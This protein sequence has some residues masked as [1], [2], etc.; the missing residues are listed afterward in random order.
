VS[1]TTRNCFGSLAVAVV[2][3]CLVSLAFA[4]PKTVRLR[5][6]FISTP[7]KGQRA[8]AKGGGQPANPHSGL[9]LIQFTGPVQGDWVHQL[10]ARGVAPVQYV[11]EDAFI[12]RANG[13]RLAE[14]EQLPF[15]RW[16]GLLRPEHKLHNQITTRL[17]AEANAEVAV[18]IL[19][20]ADS[21]PQQLGAARGLMNKVTSQSSLKFGHVWRGTINAAR[22][23]PLAASDAV[24]WVEPAPKI[25]MFDETAS[26]I[27]GG[28]SGG[29]ATLVQSLG[30][31]GRGVVVGVADSGLHEGDPDL[32]HPDL[33]GRVDA[34]M[35]YGQLTDASDEHGHG[36]HVA[37]IIG[38]N[39]ATGELDDYG[40]LWGLGVA[41]GAHIVAQRIFDGEGNF[42]A[43]PSYLDLTSD[44]IA[45]GADIGSNSWGDDTQ[46]RYDISAAEF[47]ALVRDANGSGHPYIL[48][49]S[50]GNAG[51]GAQTVGSPAVAKNVIATGASENDRFDYF[52]YTDGQ[53]A[54][55]DFSSR[56]PAEDGRIKPDITA[57][58]TWI[59][60]LRSPVGNDDFSWGEISFY[61]MF[62][63]GTSQAGPHASGAAAV[64]VQYYRESHTNATPS[65]ALVKAALINS[66]ADMDD[67]IETGPVPNM[68]EGWG[69]IDLPSL[70]GS[71]R[72]Y[73]FVDQSVTLTTGQQFERRVVISD[74][75]E[76]FKATL[77]YTDVPAFPG[78]LPALVN[79]LDLEVVAPDGHVYHGNQFDR[80]ASVPDAPGYDAI[81]N[82]ES[83]YIWEPPLGEYV[84]RVRARNVP[85]D[86]RNDT[87]AIDQDF[88]LVISG[89]IPPPT[90][91]I[92]FLDRPAYT[93]PSQIKIKVVDSSLAAQ[94]TATVRVKSTTE[95]A[96]FNVTLFNAGYPGAFS[97]TV[98]TA[99]GAAA[100][101][102]VLQVAHGDSIT[103]EYVDA[104][105]GVTRTALAI[106]DL[107]PP[108]IS[109]VTTVNQ[110]GAAVV[111]WTTDEPASSS[112]RFSTN[113][114]LNF[115]I[116][117]NT[118]V[119]MHQVEL[120]NLIV[121]RTYRFTVS[122]TD[123]AGNSSVNNNGGAL[124]SVVAPTN[125][126]VLVVDAYTHNSSQ[127][128]E[129]IP[130]S[131]YTNALR[132]A[133][134]AFDVLPA[135]NTSQSPTFV[136]LAPYKVVIWRV[137]DAFDS[138]DVLSAQQQNVIGQYLTNGG[139]FFFSSMEAISRLLDN[140]G[141]NF[142]TNVL[143]VS[144]FIRN[145]TFD[146][147]PTCDED[148]TVPDMEG[149]PQDPIG[150]GLAATIDYSHYPDFFGLFGPDF[151]D[152]FGVRHDA[153]PIFLET[154]SGEPCGMR[155][156]RSG[157][158]STGRV[159]F[160]SVPLDGIPESG[161][162]GNVK[163]A[164]LRRAMQYLIPGLDGIGIV[165]FDRDSYT[166]PDIVTI[167][168]ADSDL[169]GSGSTAVT[170]Y[171]DS[172]TNP[173]VVT[174][175]ET[176]H[177][178]IFRGAIALTNLLAPPSSAYLRANN[179]DQIHVRYL[180]ASGGITVT[181]QARVDTVPPVISN[182]AVQPDY[183]NAVI[184]WDT[185]ESSDSLVEYGQSPFLGRTAY[186][187]ELGDLHELRLDGL[188][189]DQTY[190][191]RVVS[192]DAAG[193]VDVDDNGGQ[194]YTFRTLRPLSLPFADGFDS[195]D[196]GWS[197]FNGDDSQ[198]Q[199]TLGTPN[200]GLAT[201]A[202]S[203]PNA[204]GSDLNGS[205]ADSI[206]TYLISPA[207]QLSGGN[208]V[209]LRFT[210]AYD[211][212]DTSGSDIFQYGELLLFT[213]SVSDPVSLNTY[214]DISGG[215]VQEEVDLSPYLGRVV[216][217][218]FHH[219][220]FSFDSGPRDGWL[221]DDV[222]I[223][224][225]NVM[226]GTLRVSNNLSQASFTIDGPLTVNGTGFS[227]VNTNAPPGD[228]SITFNAVPFYNTPAPQTNA[229][230]QGG[231]LVFTG[232]YTFD[233]VNNNGISDAWEQSY[234]GTVSPTRTALT[235]TDGDGMT[236][237]AEFL[238]GTNPTNAA[239]NL[240]FTQPLTQNTGV[241]RFDWPVVRGRS[242]R[243]YGSSGLKAWTPLSD[244]TRA[245]GTVLSYSAPS[246]NGLQFFRIEVKP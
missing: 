58:G 172:A 91:G 204:W 202:A 38:G 241:T 161:P 61:Y 21:T 173:I 3:F 206:D 98:A 205:A 47:D 54:M 43:P 110:Y 77:A 85:Q 72:V 174:L 136:R 185:D 157:Q 13:V 144:R 145:Q 46:G 45:A 14:L 63:G 182:V 74:A 103:V 114:S 184:T 44:A 137:N 66:A 8:A 207:I 49:F 113:T 167:E 93:A 152:T 223:S 123:A 158:D 146:A 84:V 81:N 86:A 239:S 29:H 57:P 15:V 199:W 198:V 143:H 140:G 65:P 118:L 75:S 121:G 183:E 189:T 240:H 125:A 95:P 24:L 100:N 210:H 135:T 194:L 215:W 39:G 245:N 149:V 168:V 164:I 120:T 163:A 166:V 122:S 35:F 130:L 88:A 12:A 115:G 67:S 32:M 228:Y 40:A 169:E 244:W 196:R 128:S 124:F 17:A 230:A 227:Y 153:A 193:N 53:D 10:R 99:A 221:V 90:I 142:V 232:T 129:V 235:D 192:R 219:A 109:G 162:N 5:N 76:P 23:Q 36:T 138:S 52:I 225:S 59:S 1:S 4:E 165:A 101:D 231:T 78:A 213:N 62:E 20:A 212:T 151:G 179:G 148:H 28:D 41:P 9:F 155:Y 229:L 42:E 56:G 133:G 55:A 116:S 22:L 102:G 108:V 94:Q 147:C 106:A 226:A 201:S 73:D 82:V 80:G 112:V 18:S 68:D 16:T 191:F 243:I 79:D 242:Y 154:S 203:P 134:I 97:N 7:E 105:E 31:D 238:A 104:S 87:A 37:G 187:D 96:G 64:F 27:I 51:P 25:K 186:D 117:N 200:N 150:D 6:E 34:L 214:E 246:T 171:S 236:D 30:Y 217:V 92:V 71:D 211:F 216:Y 237:V 132:A 160:L 220:L 197:L 107:I 126:P 70:I 175:P 139:S 2:W 181:A 60:S 178:G 234:F 159:V 177:R 180:D 195:G 170:C 208:S 190:Y 48:E 224:A 26:K 111:Q 11:P 69:R 83:V 209:K 119:T 188:D 218:A 50:A 222:S 176:F 33:L 141:A 131:T 156:P 19:L 233:D 127:D 89:L